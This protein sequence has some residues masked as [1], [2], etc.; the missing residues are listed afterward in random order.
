MRRFIIVPFLAATALLLCASSASA[1]RLIIERVDGVG[2][3]IATN[4]IL[5]FEISLDTEG[6][7]TVNDGGS[8]VSLA[9]TGLEG[10]SVGMLVDS[11]VLSYDSGSSAAVSYI[12]YSPNEGKGAPSVYMTPP[13]NPP[14]IWPGTVPLNTQQVNVNFIEVNLGTTRASTPRV[15][16]TTLAFTALT[17]ID[18]GSPST[19]HLTFVDPNNPATKLGGNLFRVSGVDIYPNVV[20][21]PGPIELPEPGVALLSLTALATVGGVLTVRRRQR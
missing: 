16:L 9:T 15:F 20:I 7:S 18:S 11:G 19:V 5:L 10:I 21:S 14:S 3:T 6:A 1:F 4:D 13:Q 2:N 8:N 17:T 12:L